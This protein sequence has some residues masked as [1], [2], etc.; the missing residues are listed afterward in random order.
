MKSTG[1]NPI[2]LEGFPMVGVPI[3]N[4]FDCKIDWDISVHRSGIYG[5]EPSVWR[6]LVEFF[7]F[8]DQRPAVFK[9]TW[10]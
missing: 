10:K 9:V 7:E 1:G 2:A 3:T 4:C 5:E 8:R 6:E